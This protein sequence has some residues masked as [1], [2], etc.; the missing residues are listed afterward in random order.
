[1]LSTVPAISV[2]VSVS[3]SLALHGDYTMNDDCKYCSFNGDD[4]KYFEIQ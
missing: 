1:M 4:D 3:V 2:S